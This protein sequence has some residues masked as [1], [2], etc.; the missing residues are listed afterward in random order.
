[1]S[2]VVADPYQRPF[3]RIPW[4]ADLAGVNFLPT[5]VQWF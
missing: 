2:K 4:F 3:F 5:H 1:M